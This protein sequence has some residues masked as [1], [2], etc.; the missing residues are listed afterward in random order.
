VAHPRLQAAKS[1]ARAASRY[2]GTSADPPELADLQTS[3]RRAPEARGY[4]AQ[5]APA[6]R[7]PAGAVTAEA[8]GAR[9]VRSWA[10][11]TAGWAPRQRWREQRGRAA[12]TV[13]RI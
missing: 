13:R 5:A 1:Q 9:A 10:A 8:E 2:P 7:A 12:G 6:D 3:R 11:Q 4:T